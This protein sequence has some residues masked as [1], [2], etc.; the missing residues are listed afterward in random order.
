VADVALPPWATS[1]EHFL[2][3][4]RAALESPAVSRQLHLWVDLVFGC[5]QRGPAA[6]EAD[7]VFYHLTYQ[8]AV[9]IGAVTDP[10]ERKAL[11]TQVGCTAGEGGGG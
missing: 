7:N 1:P 5:K 8:G 3:L 4:Q 10:V 9:D 2:A 6:L 11:I